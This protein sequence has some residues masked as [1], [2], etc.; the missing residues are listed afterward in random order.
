MKKHHTV[1]YLF[2]AVLLITS[3]V[4]NG[5]SAK[6]SE[7]ARKKEET[8]TK[9]IV[10]CDTYPPYSYEDAN[11]RPTGIDIDLARKAFRQ[12][13]YE[14]SFR[15]INWE[16]KKEFLEEGRIDCI[17][18]S[19]SIDGREDQYRW[20]IPYMISR[21]VV[22]VN[23]DSD[24]YRLS[25]LKGRRIAV[26]STTKP[27]ELFL[28]P[29][30]S[31]LPKVGKL[32]S[33]QN[34]ELIYPF[35]SKGYVDAVAAHETAILQY[36]KDYDLEYRILKEPLQT[37]GIGVAFSIHDDRGLEK[38]LSA[39][40]QTMRKDGSLEKIIGKYLDNPQKYLEDDADEE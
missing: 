14:P 2:F 17:W 38:K 39:I 13:G 36:M 27:E 28:D 26:Q 15:Y 4:C 23:K 30:A 1:P 37:V 32:F 29:A 18:S 40:F 25:D 12:M 9:I 34:R 8:R 24:I 7:Q 21:Q 6:T 35:L 16:K 3:L 20:T 11:G 10:G 19:Y 22:A 33:L 5:C 31:G